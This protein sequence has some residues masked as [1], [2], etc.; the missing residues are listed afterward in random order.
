MKRI[1]TEPRPHWESKVEEVGLAFHHT[2]EGLYWDE[3]AHYEFTSGE[4]DLVE[5]ATNELHE[6]CMA[7]AQDRKSTRLNSSHRT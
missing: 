7:A 5:R 2:P 4:V 3:G 1:S 6:M